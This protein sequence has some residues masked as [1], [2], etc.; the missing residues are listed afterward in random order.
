MGLISAGI[1]FSYNTSYHSS[2]KTSPTFLNL[3]RNSSPI[4]SLRR[5]T[6]AGRAIE[7]RD[8]NLWR[9]RMSRLQVLRV[10]VTNSLEEAFV[11]KSRYY[12]LRR[13]NYR[14]KVGGMVLTRCRILSSKTKQIAAKFNPRFV[15]PY[16][17]S[18]VLSPVVYEISDLTTRLIDKSRIEDLKSYIAANPDSPS[19]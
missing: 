12:N 14:L 1:A 8:P 15:G 2:L 10:Y 18:K 3:G 9:E 5:D 16:R 13:R 17:V 11:N 6:D 4:N 7:R 19:D